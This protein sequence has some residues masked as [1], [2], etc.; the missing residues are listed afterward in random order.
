[1]LH[2]LI[3]YKSLSQTYISHLRTMSVC[4]C[5]IN[6]N[7]YLLRSN[8]TSDLQSLEKKEWNRRFP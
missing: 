1:M 8:I 5:A 7:R 6:K 2:S 4:V 3:A